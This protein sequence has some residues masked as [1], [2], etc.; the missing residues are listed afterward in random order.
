MRENLLKFLQQG[1]WASLTGGWYYDSTHSS[2]TNIFHLYTWLFLLC[3]P[4]ILYL[5]VSLTWIAIIG[6]SFA[7]VVFFITLKLVNNH[8]HRT[9]DSEEHLLKRSTSSNKDDKVVEIEHDVDRDL[10]QPQP[11][12]DVPNNSDESKLK[13][14]NTDVEEDTSLDW[15]G[16]QSLWNDL[17]GHE[18]GRVTIKDTS[19]T[20]L[21]VEDEAVKDVDVE[22]DSNGN[23]IPVQQASLT[24]T[25]ASTLLKKSIEDER[26]VDSSGNLKV[27][28]GKML[29]TIAE[30]LA[31][32]SDRPSTSK[33]VLV[34]ENVQSSSRQFNNEKERQVQKIEDFRNL[35]HL[36]SSSGDEYWSESDDHH[37]SHSSS[38]WSTCN[39]SKKEFSAPTRATSRIQRRGGFRNRGRHI[40]PSAKIARRRQGF[41]ATRTSSNQQ[42]AKSSGEVEHFKSIEKR[43]KV[44][45]NDR[46]GRGDA[47]NSLTSLSSS[48]TLPTS[49]S[50]NHTV[51]SFD[52]SS[53]RLSDDKYKKKDSSASESEQHV[54]IPSEHTERSQKSSSRKRHDRYRRNA[55]TRTQSHPIDI[56]GHPRL[57]ETSFK[58]KSSRSLSNAS[59]HRHPAGDQP[60]P[61]SCE[62]KSME[63]TSFIHP[64]EEDVPGCSVRR[65]NTSE[66]KAL[67]LHRA[68][69][70]TD[71]TEGAIHSF[72]DEFGN[73]MTYT[74]GCDS[75][76]VALP[77]QHSL[78]RPTSARSRVKSSS[79]MSMQDST[80]EQ[81]TS[82]HQFRSELPSDSMSGPMQ[83]FASPRLP[84]QQQLLLESMR[85]MIENGQRVPSFPPADTSPSS[86]MSQLDIPRR[87]STPRV[88]LHYRLNLLPFKSITIQYDRLA[89]L[90]LLDR[91]VLTADAVFSVIVAG[92]VAFFGLLLLAQNLFYDVWAFWLC[93]VMA[94]SQFSLVKSVQ[95]DSASPTHGHNRIIA[96]SRPF[97]FII[98]ASLLLLFNYLSDPSNIYL[99]GIPLYGLQL[100]NNHG[101]QIARDFMFVF[102]LLLPCVFLFGLL[103]QINTF[104]LYLF[105]QTEIHAFGG[106]ASTSLAAS[107]FSLL[108]SLLTS[109][110]LYGFTYGA[111]VT[112]EGSQHILFSLF[113]G[114]L[115]SVSYHLS[116]QTT[117]LSTLWSIIKILPKS[118]DS[119]P[120]DRLSKDPATEADN[121]SSRYTFETVKS[122]LESEVILCPVISVLFFAVHCSTAF[123]ALQNTLTPVL[124][125]L[126]GGLGF[127]LHYFLPQLR[128][129]IPW[130][131]FAHPI[132]KAHEHKL[133]E[134][135]EKA[136][137]MW[138]ERV[139]MIFTFFERNVLFPV[140]IMNELTR[141]AS[142]VTTT[143]GNAFGCVIITVIGLKLV[144]NAYI[145]PSTQYL[146]ISFSKLFVTYDARNLDDSVLIS[147]YVFG[148]LF[149]KFQELIMKLQFWL[150]YICPWQITWGSALHAFAQ[151]FAVPHSAF[152]VAHAILASILQA[153]FA[154]FLG[155]ALFLSSYPRPLKFWERNYNTKRKD[156]SN[157]PLSSQI[158]QGPQ[159][160]N[161]NLNSIFYEHLTYSLQKSLAGDLALGRWGN[162]Y[163]GDCF[164]LA[165][166][167]L[168][169]MVHV[170]ELGNG[171]VTFQLR[172]LEFNGTYCQQR[173]VEAINEDAD[174]SNACCCCKIGKIKGML[175]FNAAFHHRWLAW[176]VVISNYVLEGYSISDINAT[177]MLGVFDL[178]KVIN[179]YIVKGIIYFLITHDSLEKWI[180]NENI[181][182]QLVQLEQADYAD[183]DPTF[184]GA[185]DEDYDNWLFGVSRGKFFE[186]YGSWIEHCCKERLKEHEAI[187]YSQPSKLVTLCYAITVLGR[188]ALGTASQTVSSNLDS[189]LHGLHSLFKGDF[190]ITSPKDEWV[191]VDMNLLQNVIAPGVRMALKLHQDYFSNPEEYDEYDVLYKAVEGYSSNM[192]ITHEGDPE[193]RKAV[194]CNV[195]SLLALRRVTS[196]T[197]IDQY[198][199]V[200]LNNRALG[201]SVVKV[202]RE[203]VRGLW[204]GQQNELIFL[205]NRNPERGSIQNAKQVLRNM[206]NSSCDQPIGYPIYV[207]PL[208]SSFTNSSESLNSILGGPLT[209]SRL[210]AIFTNFITCVR[211][212]CTGSCNS[213]GSGAPPPAIAM[214]PI[215]PSVAQAHCGSVQVTGSQFRQRSVQSMTSISNT[216]AS[217]KEGHVT[218]SLSSS[219][220]ITQTGQQEAAMSS[221][222]QVIF[223]KKCP[224]GS[225][226]NLDF[227][228]LSLKRISDTQGES[229]TWKRSLEF[230]NSNTSSNSNA[231]SK[232]DMRS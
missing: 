66:S 79:S 203:C 116:R 144:R 138:F 219:V 127:L 78:Y 112:K 185:I 91:N 90:D 205:R 181:R 2:F 5:A 210:R 136:R 160:D 159:S 216:E 39:S 230:A 68:A 164:I 156:H 208:T 102:V 229:G 10:E 53:L 100:F 194:L 204:A 183:D 163:P 28:E 218:T 213:G 226:S 162:V 70:H 106:S 134:V 147:Y 108:R 38:S 161:N 114:L 168:N 118:R 6:Y 101:C 23:K 117:S 214:R 113:C 45:I 189:F 206:I 105:E 150:I 3:A 180:Q 220:T 151:P 58:R 212:S 184:V 40:K 191:F 56:P 158:G 172:G 165:S 59:R 35:P 85:R 87:V 186:V 32:D 197:F 36:S 73:W 61:P 111:L 99:E 110:L 29:L 128:K 167:D 43:E 193:W 182:S 179:N 199:V 49:S 96:Y 98:S 37:S 50:I 155:S 145:S 130:L 133:F 119:D 170:V 223:Q 129:N 21:N 94:A 48:T 126:V 88:K 173:E 232:V 54:G 120:T 215:P 26:L 30:F 132:L 62:R 149:V 209:F 8:L 231:D 222:S 148:I 190:R 157:T 1:I 103:P 224:S 227:S 187:D 146:V 82:S 72:Q 109:A 124:L 125:C 4:F 75:P 153:P 97:Y 178:R 140:F 141:E 55:P 174:I 176:Q 207:S 188:R 9:F 171:L 92:I 7:I 201:F 139:Y 25:K 166:D 200:T 63:R 24:D 64:N 41:A 57:S 95:P 143:Y 121:I 34:K 27:K 104:L 65:R 123:T 175:S 42:T 198:S 71:T 84:E 67:K 60:V 83:R 17:I 154:P 135:T 44:S 20:S 69:N 142:N 86:I 74:F 169:A 16:H 137:L 221:S 11:S 13:R 228:K 152:L 93:F 177:A 217:K 15:T 77:D 192:V 211:Q 31:E 195:P 115:I 18:S 131:L 46:Q 89:L 80:T 47:S 14:Q 196:E 225:D 81:A 19:K 76:G 33:G 51:F 107:T 202:N 52:T 122:R 22:E 12:G